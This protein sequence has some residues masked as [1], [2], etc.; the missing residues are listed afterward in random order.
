MWG[1]EDKETALALKKLVNPV[2]PDGTELERL[3]TKSVPP[4]R[5]YLAH[6]ASAISGAIRIKSEDS[7]GNVLYRLQLGVGE[8]YIHQR[9]KDGI[10]EKNW[11]KPR[12]YANQYN[13]QVREIPVKRMAYNL[14]P[15]PVALVDGDGLNVG[16]MDT[17]LFCV[18][19]ILG[20][21]FIVKVCEFQE[22]GSSSSSSSSWSSSSSNS[23]SSNNSS[24]S[25]SSESSEGSSSCSCDCGCNAT[26]NVPFVSSLHLSGGTLIAQTGELKFKKGKFC[27]YEINGSETINL[28]D[29]DCSFSGGSESESV[30]SE[31]ESVNCVYCL[32]EVTIHIHQ[33]EDPTLGGERPAIEADI[34][35][36]VPWCEFEINDAVFWSADAVPWPFSCTKPVV[37]GGYDTDGLPIAKIV[38]KGRIIC[39]DEFHYYNTDNPSDTN[40][41][42]GKKQELINSGLLFGKQL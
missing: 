31:S 7:D 14:C 28:C 1:F 13:P 30:G 3:P 36:W 5:A 27:G 39:Y 42:V 9:D 19:D 11:T 20:D 2:K 12:R 26:A 38:G 32:Q 29:L 16:C 10:I 8:V 35:G 41:Y 21:L 40:T 4:L 33:L 37:C 23:S 15:E 25:S 17:M 22:C 6:P 34:V 24:S 18:E